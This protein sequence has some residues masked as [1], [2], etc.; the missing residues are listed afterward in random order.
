MFWSRTSNELLYTA[1]GI[2]TRVVSYATTADTFV[3]QQPRRLME[4]G[5]GAPLTGVPELMPDGKQFIVVTTG[6]AGSA[7]ETRLTFLLN[8]AD[9]LKRRFRN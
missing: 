2:G 1:A 7:R 5:W 8:F 6:P 4:R 9:E 3:A